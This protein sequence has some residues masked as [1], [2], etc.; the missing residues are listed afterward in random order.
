M[1]TILDKFV[2]NL[3]GT[4]ATRTV[5]AYERTARSFLEFLD[6]RSCPTQNDIEQFLARPLVSGSPRA[7]ATRN[8]ELAGIRSLA[9]LMKSTGTWQNNP[10]K[11]IR[12][13]KESRKD[14]TFL[15]QSELRQLFE[16]AA[17]TD[18]A[19]ERS[20]N[21]AIIALLSQLGLRVHELVSLN[22]P[23]VDTRSNTLLGVH[24]KGDTRIDMP[25]SEEVTSILAEWIAT[26]S[27][28]AASVEPALFV[29]GKTRTRVSVRSVERL[30]TSLWSKCG[31]TKRISPHSLRHTTGT[32]LITLGIDI[33][34]VG[35]LL[36][37]GSLDVTRRYVGLVG[38]RRRVAVQKLAITIPPEVIPR[39]EGEPRS[40]QPI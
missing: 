31:S 40:V 5:L 29:T 19:I 38:A 17:E 24:G 7:A 10:T 8:H 32:L 33:S 4:R 34:S 11:G 25:M 23:Q 14:P 6:Q 3:Q 39:Q 9:R 27:A 1:A 28:W 16:A 20:R 18:D 13:A 30:V 36:R 22:I 37:H 12:F 26:R 35:D 21:I 15:F 2:K